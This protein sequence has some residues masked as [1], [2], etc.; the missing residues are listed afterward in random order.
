MIYIYIYIY[1]HIY[2]YICYNRNDVSC[3]RN[4]TIDTHELHTE[5]CNALG[6]TDGVISR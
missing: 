2:I 4:L 3:Q 1:T 5:V 6:T